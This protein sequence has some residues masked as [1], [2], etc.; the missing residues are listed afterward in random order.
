M[1]IV[2]YKRLKTDNVLS[3]RPDKDFFF[4]KEKYFYYF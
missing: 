1:F 2:G 4:R 3:K